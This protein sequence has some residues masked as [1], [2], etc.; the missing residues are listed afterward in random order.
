MSTID[1]T[2]SNSVHVSEN[3]SQA[4]LVGGSATTGAV[5]PLN[6]YAI[7]RLSVDYVAKH[8]VTF[9]LGATFHKSSGG[10]DIEQSV[11]TASGEGQQSWLIAVA[12]GTGFLMHVTPGALMWIRV[13]GTLSKQQSENPTVHT[14]TLL[15]SF[16]LALSGVFRVVDPLALVVS[17]DLS[18]PFDG[19]TKVRYDN[20]FANR[21]GMLANQEFN[22]HLRFVALQFGTIM[23]L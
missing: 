19:I 10:W 16:D 22:A 7:P 6:V 17:L 9:G 14:D 8:N 20:G 15:G 21:N 18:L 1:Y 11:A 4:T 5:V 3:G 12:P 2:L 23:Y 13:G